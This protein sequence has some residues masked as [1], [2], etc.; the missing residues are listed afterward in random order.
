MYIISSKTFNELVELRRLKRELKAENRELTTEVEELRKFKEMAEDI[1]GQVKAGIKTLQELEEEL[2]KP[3][4][5]ASINLNSPEVNVFSIDRTDYGEEG[6]C[7]VIGYTIDDSNEILE[8]DLDI[9]RAQHEELVRQYSEYSNGAVN[10][11]KP[12]T[13]SSD[14]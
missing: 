1:D 4:C 10:T 11:I 12:T 13:I 6:E 2:K 3:V 5:N 14:E 9:S 8:W 7:T